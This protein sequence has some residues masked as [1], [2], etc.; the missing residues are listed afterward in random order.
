ML[1]TKADLED[2]AKSEAA[3]VNLEHRVDDLGNQLSEH[4]DLAQQASTQQ[5]KS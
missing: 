4:K 2:I 3:V 5:G 1:Q